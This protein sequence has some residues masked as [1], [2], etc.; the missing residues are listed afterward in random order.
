MA[1]KVKISYTLNGEQ[2][3]LEGFIADDFTA[4]AEGHPNQLTEV[5]VFK[6]GRPNE[7]W[8]IGYRYIFGLYFDNAGAMAYV[9]T[10]TNFKGEWLHEPRPIGIQLYDEMNADTM[11]GGI[12]F[13]IEILLQG[14]LGMELNKKVT[15]VLSV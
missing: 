7:K 3:R 13:D 2:K 4:P 14:H 10:A 12:A 1:K 9:E 15:E 8:D 11:T 5:A 6:S